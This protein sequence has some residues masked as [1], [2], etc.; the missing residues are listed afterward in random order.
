[1]A[2]I[3]YTTK[4]KKLKSVGYKK[5]YEWLNNIIFL[6]LPYRHGYGESS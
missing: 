3:H 2:A 6:L 1:M 5:Y 4:P